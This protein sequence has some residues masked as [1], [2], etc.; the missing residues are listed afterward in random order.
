MTDFNPSDADVEAAGR[1]ICGVENEQ[2]ARYNPELTRVDVD[3]ADWRH[4]FDEKGRAVAV[5][6]HGAGW[7]TGDEVAA[8]EGRLSK[9]PS[10]AIACPECGR[11][12]GDVIDSLIRQRGRFKARRLEAERK[13]A[14]YRVLRELAERATVALHGPT[15]NCD[16]EHCRIPP[17]DGRPS[18]AEWVDALRAARKTDP[19]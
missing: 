9:S 1:A 19:L 15:H 17:R 8:L 10:S 2:D 4:E 13:L 3:Y 5:A 16:I 12:L 7:R 14:R 11:K 18:C 6:L